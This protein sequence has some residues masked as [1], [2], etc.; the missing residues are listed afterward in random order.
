[1]GLRHVIHF[2]VAQVH[3]AR[4]DFM[5]L[6]FP[7]VGAVFI[8]QRDKRALTSAI[9]TSELGRELQTASATTHDDNFV[10]FAYF[11]A[12]DQVNQF[13]LEHQATSNATSQEQPRLKSLNEF[14]VKRNTNDKLAEI[15]Y[16]E[17][18]DDIEWRQGWA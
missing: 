3:A 1:M 11:H 5:Q 6:G 9:A 18:Q 17:L 7:N 12:R 13:R 2:V 10:L 15:A 4:S 8:D 14:G 16:P